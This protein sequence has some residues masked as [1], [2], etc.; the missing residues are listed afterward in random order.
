MNTS[1]ASVS[2][3]EEA[4]IRAVYAHRDENLSA[5]YHWAQPNILL[6]EYRVRAASATCLA[7][8]GWKD[9]SGLRALDVGCGVGGWLRTLLAWGARAENLHAV[10]V[11][12]DRIETARRLAPQIDFQVGAGWKLPFAEAS[13]DLVSAHSVFSSVLDEEIRTRMAGEIMRVLA[14]GGCVLIFDCRINPLN[15]DAIGIRRR[16]L[17]RLFPGFRQRTRSMM[18]P[19]PMARRMVRISPWVVMA[20]EALCPP[21]RAFN[22]AMLRRGE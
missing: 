2:Q 19:P 21:L 6:G 22:I 15:R 10:D 1:E 20:L 4:R 14:P 7:H 12:P 11:L 8:A 16:E 5:L 3:G 13:M 9:L 17:R 18:L